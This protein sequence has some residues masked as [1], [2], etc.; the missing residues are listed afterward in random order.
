MSGT[1]LRLSQKSNNFTI[2]A[3]S[4][5]SGKRGGEINRGQLTR[6]LSN[7]ISN[8]PLK[9]GP[10][11]KKTIQQTKMKIFFLYYTAREN[12]TT[13]GKVSLIRNSGGKYFSLL[14]SDFLFLPILWNMEKLFDR[15]GR[16]SFPFFP[17][18]I[19]QFYY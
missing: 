3:L 10:S 6:A 16:F 2:T 7:T 13:S 5:I 8:N 11:A 15:Y 4:K 12:K 18:K 19:F 14:F 1:F 17:N 9:I